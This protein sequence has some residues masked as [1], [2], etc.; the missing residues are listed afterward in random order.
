MWGFLFVFLTISIV[1]AVCVFVMIKYKSLCKTRFHWLLLSL[2]V[3]DLICGL[4]LGTRI[5][6][7][8]FKLTITCIMSEFVM[9]GSVLLSLVETSLICLER[10]NATYYQPK[11]WI[12]RVTSKPAIASVIAICMLIGVSLG[13]YVAVKSDAQS[14]STCNVT[15]YDISVFADIPLV[16][17]CIVITGSYCMVIKRMRQRFRQVQPNQN[18]AVSVTQR[19]KENP[20]MESSTNQLSDTSRLIQIKKGGHNDPKMIRKSENALNK[21][22]LQSTSGTSTS[23][24][25]DMSQKLS[26]NNKSGNGASNLVTED[27]STNYTTGEENRTGCPKGKTGERKSQEKEKRFRQN[28]VT[29]GVIITITFLAVLPKCVVSILIHTYPSVISS[30][31]ISYLKG[32]LLI[33]PICD[34]FVYLLR[35]KEFKEKVNPCSMC[36]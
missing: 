25:H 16:T 34:P 9:Y 33:N 32:F 4:A 27:S 14:S 23:C 18:V 36:R 6:S 19:S 20:S 2:S 35:I 31:Q 29:L 26:F 22:E 12:Q 13:A 7:G 8:Q 15:A 30:S 3:S 28:M 10:L 17:A 21:F 1:N 11:K 5:V 24:T